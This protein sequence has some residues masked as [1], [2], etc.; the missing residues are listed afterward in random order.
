[1]KC[2]FGLGYDIHKLTKNRKLFLGGV[3][4][5]HGKGLLGHSDADVVLHA[6]CDA[7]LGAAGLGDIGE[8]FPDTDKK[9][10]NA[11]SELFIKETWRRVK[12][13][14]FS[15]NNID[16]IIMCEK[17]KLGH[18]KLQIKRKIASMIGLSSSLVNV[19]AKT[20]EGMGEIGRD[21][22][23]AAYATVSLSKKSRV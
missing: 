19:K 18:Y 17:P 13:K 2:Y 1:M 8:I 14:K 16:L 15:I 7:M 23:I 20:N 10:K 5:S 12:K 3:E 4:I 11:S 22:A 6:L 9:F 21:K